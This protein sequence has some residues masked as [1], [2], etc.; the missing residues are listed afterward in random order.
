MKAA[1]SAAP[2]RARSS[3]R[4]A[5]HNLVYVSER[6]ADGSTFRTKDEEHLITTT[7]RWFRPVWAGVGPDGGFYMADW[8]DTRLSHV[9]PIDDW[10]KNQR[11]HLS[12]A[13]CSGAPKLKPFD[14]HTAMAMN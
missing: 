4:T 14:L 9:S 5:L 13:T 6:I 11:P 7:D 10:H 12:R 1:C 2:T 3:R 8:Y